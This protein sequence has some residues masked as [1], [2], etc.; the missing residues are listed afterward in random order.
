MEIMASIMNDCAKI[1]GCPTFSGDVPSDAAIFE[2]ALR[3]RVSHFSTVLPV[4]SFWWMQI[5]NG[6]PSTLV[7]GQHMNRIN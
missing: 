2:S 7:D 3:F 6:K 5:R 4:A 1:S